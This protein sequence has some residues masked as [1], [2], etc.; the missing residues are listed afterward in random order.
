MVH[1][2]LIRMLYW[3]I[4]QEIKNS[5]DI[6]NLNSI[7]QRCKNYNIINQQWIDERL[8]FTTIELYCEIILSLGSYTS[9][10]A[11]EPEKSMFI[12]TKKK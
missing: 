10:S 6:N 2:N 9:S 5:D 4:V 11:I 3:D 7:L 12:N 8:G 1:G